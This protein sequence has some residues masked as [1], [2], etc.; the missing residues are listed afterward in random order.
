[1]QI[2]QYKDYDEYLHE[3]IKGTERKLSYQYVLEKDL[4][5]LMRLVE[6][7]NPKNIL[8]HGVRT[9]RELW[10]LYKQLEE[11]GEEYRVVGTEICEQAIAMASRFVDTLDTV[12]I[13]RWDMNL[14][15]KEFVDNFD[16]VYSNSLDHAFNPEETLF[17]WI[18]Q[19]KDGGILAIHWDDF[20]N[21]SPQHGGGSDAPYLDPF[22]ATSKEIIYFLENDLFNMKFI[23]KR[24]V[25]TNMKTQDSMLLIFEKK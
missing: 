17:T 3:Q 16:M 6:Y 22:R 9:G 4:K 14:P 5:T 21:A 2:H 10:W 19:I 12:D 7:K 8:C 11:K 20:N 1:M 25:K 23:E 18:D 24:Y 13:I 15:K